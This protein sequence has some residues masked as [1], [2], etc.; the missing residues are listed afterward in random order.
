MSFKIS[1]ILFAGLKFVLAGKPL[2]AYRHHIDA[3]L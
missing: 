2:N 3:D 1:V